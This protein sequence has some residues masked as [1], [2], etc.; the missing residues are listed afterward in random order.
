[1]T[2]I[3]EPE[4]GL[5]ALGEINRLAQLDDGSG[6]IEPQLISYLDSLGDDAY[7]MPCLRIAGQT[8]LGEVLTGLG[9]DERVAEVLRRNIQDSV[10][11]PGMSEEEALQARAAQVVVV[12]LLRIIARMEAVELRNVVAQ[13]RLA[14]QIPPVV[15]VALTL[16]VDILDAARL[17]AHPDDMVRVVLDYA[18][19]VLWLADDDLN[20]YFAEL[21]MIVQQREKDLEFGRFGEPG[22]ARFG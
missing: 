2:L 15:R 3:L 6:I 10:V 5:E 12:R 1:M 7:D 8:L 18:D 9:E 13:Q 14:L 16:T 11:L 17:D 4:E 20:A 21:E 22:A 19:Q